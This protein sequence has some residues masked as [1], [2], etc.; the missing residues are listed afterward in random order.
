M[1]TSRK[2]L[3]SILAT[4]T[5]LFATNGFAD[6]DDDDRYERGYKNY[7]YHKEYRGDDRYKRS[8]ESKCGND[9]Y[10]KYKKS[11]KYHRGSKGR[12]I[13]GAVYDLDL[14]KE[15]EKKI[16]SFMRDFQ[17]KRSESYNAFKNDSFDKQ[18]YIDARMKRQENMIKAKADLIENIYSVLTPKQKTELKKEID[19]FERYRR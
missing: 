4:S 16:D 1:K 6:D 11:E 8:H 3:L 12:F 19:S 18:A 10:R 13:I 15:Q 7:G 14:S 17:E 9:E 2:L 5:L